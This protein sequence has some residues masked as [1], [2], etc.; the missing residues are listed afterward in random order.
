[1]NNIFEGGGV[2]RPIDDLGRIVLPKE[3]R[4]LLNLNDGSRLVVSVVD[5]S[6]LLLSLPVMVC[7][8]CHS[9][10]ELVTYIGLTVCDSCIDALNKERKNI[11]MLKAGK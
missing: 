5:E 7:R 9:P 6:S 4:Q 11:Q 8:A 3:M 10:E 2:T 1:M